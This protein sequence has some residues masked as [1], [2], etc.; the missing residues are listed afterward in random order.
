MINSGKNRKTWVPQDNDYEEY[1][2]PGC[3]PVHNGNCLIVKSDEQAEQVLS[4]KQ[5]SQC[6]APFRNVG[7]IPIQLFLPRPVNAAM[8]FNYYLRRQSTSPVVLNGEDVSRGSCVPNL[9][10]HNVISSEL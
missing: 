6:S 3:D 10:L 5:N 8:S 9:K 1:N 2:L 4:T 7:R